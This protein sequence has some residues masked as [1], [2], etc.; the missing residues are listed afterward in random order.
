MLPKLH[1]SLENSLK[2]KFCPSSEF[3]RKKMKK[4]KTAASVIGSGCLLSIICSLFHI[5][6]LGCYQFVAFTMDID[7]LN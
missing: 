2:Y 1:P 6:N 4:E 7:D 5:F 3:S